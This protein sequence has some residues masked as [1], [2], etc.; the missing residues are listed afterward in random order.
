MKD[1]GDIYYYILKNFFIGG[2]FFTRKYF[3][4]AEIYYNKATDDIAEKCKKSNNK[5]HCEL[6]YWRVFDAYYGDS[7]Y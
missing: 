2:E 4:Q 6:S 7:Y 5:E 1:A 3:K